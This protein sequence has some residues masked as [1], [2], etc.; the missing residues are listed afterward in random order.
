MRKVSYKITGLMPMKVNVIKEKKSR[1]K[2]NEEIPKQSST[3]DNGLEGGKKQ[4]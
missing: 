2:E 4:L 3:L 1:L